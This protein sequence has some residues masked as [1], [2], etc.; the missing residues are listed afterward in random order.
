MASNAPALVMLYVIAGMTLFGL[1]SLREHQFYRGLE[2]FGGLDWASNCDRYIRKRP[3]MGPLNSTRSLLFST[4]LVRELPA[5]QEERTA[6]ESR[7][8]QRDRAGLR[9]AGW[10][11][12]A[13]D[14]QRRDRYA[15]ESN[16]ALILDGLQAA[17]GGERYRF[18]SLPNQRH[19]LPVAERFGKGGEGASTDRSSRVS[20]I[21]IVHRPG[22]CAD[23]ILDADIGEADPTR[24]SKIAEVKPIFGMATDRQNVGVESVRGAEVYDRGRAARCNDHVE[25]AKGQR[26]DGARK[27]GSGVC[28]H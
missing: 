8:E 23:V 7:A 22:C 16:V 3:R 11:R 4:N 27:A 20:H 24:C 1:V 18:C 26:T 10:D 14:Q 15:V 28:G 17:N 5:P 12:K 2:V 25:V 21:G 9:N 13:V 6:Q 19:R